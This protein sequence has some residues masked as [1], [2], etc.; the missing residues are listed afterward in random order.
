M[1]DLA[2]WLD[3]ALRIRLGAGG[4]Q[5]ARRAQVIAAAAQAIDEAGPAVSMTRIAELA[6]IPRPHIYRY[7]ENRETLEAEV[8]R[9]ASSDLV[10]RV[11]PHFTRPGLPYEVVHGVLT[12]IIEWAAEHAN[13]YRFI[14][15]QQQTKALHRVRMGRT[16]FLDEIVDATSAYLRPTELVGDA[17]DGVLA[18]VIGMADAGI[19]WWLDHKDETPDELIARLARQVTVV[20]TDALKQLGLEVPADMVFNPQG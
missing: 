8:A 15:A 11:R 1:V 4:E 19:I 13:L 12:P 3:A 9:L 5:T 7:V 18:S 17:P 16:R 2:K 10:Q 20:L 6:D 14:A